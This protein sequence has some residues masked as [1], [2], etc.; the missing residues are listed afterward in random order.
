MLALYSAG[1]VLSKTLM[2]QISDETLELSYS[3]LSPTELTQL[4][5]S[6]KDRARIAQLQIIA[7]RSLGFES[8]E[9]RSWLGVY[10]ASQGESKPL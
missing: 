1:H 9:L 3:H 2:E 7:L 8:I 5:D 4:C 6:D 10:T